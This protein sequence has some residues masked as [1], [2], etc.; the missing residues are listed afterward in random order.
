MNFISIQATYSQSHIALFNESSCLEVVSHVDARSSSHLVPSV[1][2]LLQKHD[3]TLSD[4][5]FFALDKGPGAFTSLRVTVATFN[6]IAFSHKI[7][8]I[9]VD[10]LDALLY[11]MRVHSGFHVALLNAYNNDVYYAVSDE[12]N[13]LLQKGCK[14]S[15]LLLRDLKNMCFPQTIYFS[16]NGML[17]CK[18]TIKNIFSDSATIIE[19][20]QETASVETIGLLALEQYSCQNEAS[21]SIE[22]FYLKTQLFAVRPGVTR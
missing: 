17:L 16:G 3:I 13:L 1:Q 19:P 11:D 14:N 15:D 12:H 22:P 6:G 4:L 7:P 21:Y 8:L 20:I 18:D 5:S 2:N 10:G 9:G